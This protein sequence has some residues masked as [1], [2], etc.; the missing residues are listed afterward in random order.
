MFTIH[1]PWIR[2]LGTAVFFVLLFLFGAPM[3]AGIRNLGNMAGICMSLIGLLFFAANPAVSSLL[4]KIWQ[5]GAG[6]FI[7]CVMIGFLVFGSILAA[8]ISICMGAAMHR[9]PRT[10]QPVVV[11]G[12]QV[13]STGPSLMLRRRLDAAYTYL[14]EH[15]D[16]P[17]IVCGGQGSNEPMTE[18]EGMYRYLIEKGIAA[19]RILMEDTSTSTYEN[20]RNAQ[21]ILDSKGLGSSITIVTDGYHQLRA[22]MIAQSLGLKAASISA[23]TSWYM[24]PTYW[25]REW[26]GVC[27]QGVLG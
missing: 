25:V 2:I 1:A 10:E 13:N 22:S 16:V 11:L 9:T 15:P 3:A 4:Q 12:C 18:A 24:V 8:G 5:N 14:T 27:Y 19:D 6:H 23:A 21:A 17:V 20:L 26:M 7:L